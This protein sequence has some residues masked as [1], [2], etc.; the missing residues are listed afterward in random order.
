MPTLRILNY[1]LIQ[2]ILC[3]IISLSFITWVKLKEVD[4]LLIYIIIQ[5]SNENLDPQANEE[6]LNVNSLYYENKLEERI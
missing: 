4:I 6:L 1:Q 3:I 5:I 2:L